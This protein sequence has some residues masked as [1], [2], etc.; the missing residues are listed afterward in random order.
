MIE[1]FL[2]KLDTDPDNILFEDTMALI[3]SMYD[4]KPT[5]FSN[6]DQRNAVGENSGS[7]K[8]F[9]FAK[10]NNLSEQ[11]TLACF[12]QYYRDVLEDPEG[13]SHQNIR[14]FI[15]NGWSGFESSKLVLTRKC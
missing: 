12:G 7:C 1:T 8:L 6:G 9:N 3:D 2:Q 14:Q 4:F 10:L 15:I 11:Q 13:D 5:A